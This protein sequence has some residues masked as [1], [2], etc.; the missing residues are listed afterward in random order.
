MRFPI[1]IQ[2]VWIPQEVTN[3]FLKRHSCCFLMMMENCSDQKKFHIYI[4]EFAVRL[5]LIL[6]V[7]CCS[8]DISS[9][10]VTWKLCINL[11]HKVRVREPPHLHFTRSS[12]KWINWKSEGGW[13]G[14][15]DSVAVLPP[16]SSEVD[17]KVSLKCAFAHT[18]NEQSFFKKTILMHN[19]LIKDCNDLLIHGTV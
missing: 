17:R 16:C 3:L 5:C 11:C 15:K 9:F 2:H 1:S 19:F 8:C 14:R 6:T 12:Q 13:K 10:L 7:I 18:E 4:P